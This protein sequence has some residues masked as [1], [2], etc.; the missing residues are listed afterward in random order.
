MSGK[1]YL[2]RIFPGIIKVLLSYKTSMVYL[3]IFAISIAIATFIENDF[4]TRA[5]R[6]VVYDAAWFELLLTLIG[7]SIVW[8]IFSYKIWRKKFPVFLFHISFIVVLLGA[9]TTRYFSQEGIMHIREGKTSNEYI[10]SNAYIDIQTINGQDTVNQQQEVTFSTF[11]E[12]NYN[13]TLQANGRKI[14]FQSTRFVPNARLFLSQSPSGHP[15]LQLMMVIDGKSSTEYFNHKEVKT[16]GS[17][18][19]SFDDTL[20]QADIYIITDGKEL[21]MKS[22]HQVTL[23][24]KDDLSEK[25]LAKNLRHPFNKKRLYK[26]GDVQLVLKKYLS[27]GI[28]RARSSDQND[29]LADVL[30]MEVTGKNDSADVLLIGGPRTRGLPTTF[31]LDGIKTN[32]RYGSK[33]RSLPFSLKLNDFIMEKYPAT[34]SPASFRSELTLIDR[35]KEI[36]RP[37]SIFMNNVLNHRGYRFYQTSYDEDEK[38]TYLTVNRDVPGTLITYLGYILVF[39]GMMT[40]LFNRNSRF[41][42]L[43]RN[44]K[45]TNGNSVSKMKTGLVT[46][47]IFTLFSGSAIAQPQTGNN[48]NSFTISYEHARSAGKLM[49]QGNKGRIKPLS[50]MSSELLRKI[51]RQS[52][53]NNLHSDQVLLSMMAYP[54]HWKNESLIKVGHPQLKKLLNVS[55]SHAT[56]ADFSRGTDQEYILAEYVNRAYQKKP[57][58]RNKFDNEVIKVHER[59]H[60]CNLIFTT[61]IMKIFPLPGEPNHEWLD[62]TRVSNRFE[63][64]D[65]L[66]VNKIVPLYLQTLREAENTGDWD[67]AGMYLQSMKDFQQ[68]YASQ[69]LPSKREVNL[70]I[71]YYD[72]NI[73]YKLFKIYGLIGIILLIIQFIQVLTGGWDLKK[74][75]KVAFFIVLVLFVFHTTGLAMRW[76]I[77]GHA[78]WSNGYEAL[79]YISWATILAGL[80]FSFK[81]EFT[82]TATLILSSLILHVAHLS[83]M[84]PAITQLVPVL[85]SYWLVIH[86]AVITA[87]YSFLGM[88]AVL[89]LINLILMNFR[90]EKNDYRIQSKTIELSR[91]IELSII[92]GLYLLVTGTMLGA[93]WANQSWGRYWAWDPKETWALITILVYSVILHLRVVPGM[94]NIYTLNLLSVIGFG[95]VIMTYFGVNYYLSGMHS[96]AQG[97]PLPIPPF[98]YYALVTLLILAIFSYVNY[99]KFNK[100]TVVSN[101]K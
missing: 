91:I 6:V 89:A 83:W 79:T 26:I 101:Q 61:R 85:R 22:P 28:I 62:P 57:V 75:W 97:D 45:N 34:S 42:K 17:F 20:A 39:V 5:A 32:I 4:S 88:G 53:Y 100:N 24:N 73:F 1:S 33:T 29:K 78:P 44:S 99:K 13:N 46:L 59:V 60:L 16:I 10:S 90:T 35:E 74:L 23:V 80:I 93:V 47:L 48:G 9:G 49:V 52:S 86:V 40:S 68:K 18:R 14:R 3:G 41:V 81:S 7:I 70:E 21:K 69:I 54:Q 63:D 8:N 30:Y 25:D 72:L 43:L 36:N 84:D 77:S 98:L 96:Y 94:I 55:G 19:V 51:A 38:G 50:T 65:S 66:Y 37:V 67:A 92:I 31:H 11:S 56:F 2:S 27:K 12:D 95:S 64:K 71:W 76:I 58:N 15:V 82:L 87:S